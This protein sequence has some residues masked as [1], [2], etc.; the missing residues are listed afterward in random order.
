MKIGF[1]FSWLLLFIL[2][3]CK[4]P[5][6]DR[7]LLGEKKA[8]EYLAKALKDSTDVLYTGNALIDNQETAIKLSEVLLFKIYGEDMIKA[9]RPYEVH[10]ID[11]YWILKGT[12]PVGADGGTFFSIIFD[13]RDGRVIKL[14]HTR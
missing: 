7:L 8:R 14:L 10:F 9:E 3:S 2:V 5:K 6:E 4:G 11:G 1:V 13:S 12:L